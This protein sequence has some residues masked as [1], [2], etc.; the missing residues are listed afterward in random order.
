MFF[1]TGAWDCLFFARVGGGVCCYDW[2]LFSGTVNNAFCDCNGNPVFCDNSCFLLVLSA[3]AAGAGEACG[4]GALLLP[5]Y[6]F[7]YLWTTSIL[8]H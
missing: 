2:R 3:L 8:S 5:I 6:D 7:N 4:A 1:A